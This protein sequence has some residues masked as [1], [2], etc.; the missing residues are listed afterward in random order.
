MS[1][2]TMEIFYNQPSHTVPVLVQLEKQA[3]L[4]NP[5]HLSTCCV[6]FCQQA[7]SFSM[8]RHVNADQVDVFWKML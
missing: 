1:L 5:L 8:T 4:V 2:T 3:Y 6:T 7:S